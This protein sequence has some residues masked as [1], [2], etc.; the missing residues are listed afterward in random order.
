VRAPDVEEAQLFK[1]PE[2]GRVGV[3]EIF[4][5]AFDQNDKPMRLTITVCPIDRNQLAVEF[6]SPHPRAGG[7]N[8]QQ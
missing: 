5:R 4:R 7:K 3:F 6:G 8:Q 2:D 1:L